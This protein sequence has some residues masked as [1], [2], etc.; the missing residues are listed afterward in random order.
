MLIPGK[1]FDL[2]GKG[3]KKVVDHVENPLVSVSVFIFVLE[4]QCR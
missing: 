2:R 3:G 1:K 4:P